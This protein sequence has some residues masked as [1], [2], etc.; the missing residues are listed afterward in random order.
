MLDHIGVIS[1]PEFDLQQVERNDRLIGGQLRYRGETAFG[2]V[3][4]APRIIYIGLVVGRMGRISGIG[5]TILEIRIGFILVA[6]L[7]GGMPRTVIILP[8]ARIGQFVG[9]DGQQMF[10]GPLVVALLLQDRAES[11][12]H[13]S[14]RSNWDSP[15]QNR[16]SISRAPS[17]GVRRHRAQH[18]SGLAS[19]NR[20]HRRT[21]PRGPS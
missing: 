2:S 19:G 21:S 12:G 11:E 9:I 4:I 17:A 5:R 7:V 3:Q 18:N 14:G 1:L 16:S 8:D 10:V 20:H 15:R 6:V 13:D